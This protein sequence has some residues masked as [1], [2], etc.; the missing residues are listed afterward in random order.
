MPQRIGVFGGTFDPP[1]VGH[2]VT[3]VNVRHAL[4]LDTVLLMV[5]NEPWQKVERG[6]SPPA[7]QRLAMVRAAVADVPGL[8]A[9]DTEIDHGGPSYTADTLEALARTRPGASLLHDPPGI[10]TPRWP[11]AARWWWSTARASRWV[12]PQGSPG[13]GWRCRGST[14]PAPICAIAAATGVRSTTWSPS[15]CCT[16]SARWG[17]TRTS[18]EC[19][20][21][22]SQEANRGDAHRQPAGGGGARWFRSRRRQSAEAV[23]GRHQG[24]RRVQDV[25]HHAGWHAGHGRLRR[26]ADQHRHLRA[27]GRRPARRQHRVGAGL[28]GFHSGWWRRPRSAHT[29]VRR[30]R[31]RSPGVGCGERAVHHH[32]RQFR[33][34]G[35]RRGGVVEPRVAGGGTVAHRCA[36]H[37]EC[38]HR[39]LV[40]RR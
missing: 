21:K 36:G 18:H 31:R 3:A 27:Q 5:A 23:R 35:G 32:R 22:C 1:H 2:L 9:G 39:H 30:R 20:R 19:A 6:R 38:R 13:S 12:C 8:E 4:R 26:R 34:I 14:C 28:V 17:C 7:R 10:A 40:R 33:C 16:S 25:A 37:V 29:G 15:P 11:S 24:E